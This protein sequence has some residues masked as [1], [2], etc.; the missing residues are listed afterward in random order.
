[1]GEGR[2]SRSQTK[3]CISVGCIRSVLAKGLCS[4]HYQRMAKKGELGPPGPIN[5]M[6][7]KCSTKG[8]LERSIREG[9]CN[10]HYVAPLSN[11]I[12]LTEYR[13]TVCKRYFPRNPTGTVRKRCKPCERVIR[14]ARQREQYHLKKGGVR[15][16]ADCKKDL[17]I[18]WGPGRALCSDCRLTPGQRN[19]RSSRRR[20]Y[21]IEPVDFVL[22]LASQNFACAICK[23]AEIKGSW[24][25][26]HD[27]QSGKVRGVLCSNCNTALGLTRENLDT[28]TEMVRYLQTG[29][30]QS[31]GVTQ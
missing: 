10:L 27:H 21:G 29:A 3:L 6:W 24:H 19:T 31:N 25:L 2:G 28:L 8:C 20:V 11:G 15:K 16:C 26:D 1:M 18:P 22:L 7:A 17:D 9:K 4:L 30:E 23:N 5:G 12:S 13:C 14:N